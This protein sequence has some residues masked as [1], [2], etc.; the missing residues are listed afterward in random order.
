MAL[1]SVEAVDL[2]QFAAAL[3]VRLEQATMDL[4]RKRGAEREKEW[5]AAA[6]EL[7][8]QTSTSASGMLERARQLPELAGLRQELAEPL[9]NQWVDALEK[10][11]AGIAFHISSRSP[12]IEALYPS[13]KLAPLRRASPDAVRKFQ[14]DFEK[15]LKASYVARLLASDDFAFA[16]PVIDSIRN[17][18]TQWLSCFADEAIPEAEAASIREALEAAGTRL[19]LAIRQARHLAEAALAP[20]PEIFEAHPLGAKPRKRPRPHG[21][22]AQQP[23]ESP[24]PAAEAPPHASNTFAQ[25]ES[26]SGKSSAADTGPTPTAMDESPRRRKRADGAS[27]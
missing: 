24:A 8:N 20:F 13:Q 16:R 11:L 27:R 10:L 23:S 18:H 25:E 2:L 21:A 3:S 4:S 19:D 6:G 22:N 14:A 7:L 15:R 9:Q 5:L 26:S 1:S 17:A 12:V